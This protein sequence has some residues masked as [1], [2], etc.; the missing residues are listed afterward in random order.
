MNHQNEKLRADFKLLLDESELIRA[1]QFKF[2]FLKERFIQAH[3]QLRQI[4]IHYLG[5]NPRI[6]KTEQGKPYLKDF[7]AFQFNL[8][9]S[10]TK[11]V[12]AVTLDTPVGIDIECTN[13]QKKIDVLS[14]AER[15]FSQKEFQLLK[16]AEHPHQLFFKLWTRKEAYIKLLGKKLLH[17]IKSDIPESIECHDFTVDENTLGTLAIEKC[18]KKMEL[19]HWE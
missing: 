5:E 14:M 2:D 8:S 7:L 4:L 13:S 16:S 19:K 11:A 18:L 9:H 10:G 6:N 15:F 1:N 12:C 17:E 3:G